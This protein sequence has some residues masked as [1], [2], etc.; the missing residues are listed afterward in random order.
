MGFLPELMALIEP[1]CS[2]KKISRCTLANTLVLSAKNALACSVI[3]RNYDLTM[4]F[5]NASLRQCGQCSVIWITT[6]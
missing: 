2:V 3:S 5:C 1:S 4:Q 6:W